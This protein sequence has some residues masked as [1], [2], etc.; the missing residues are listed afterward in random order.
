MKA[1]I[2]VI[3]PV[4][5]AARYL[6]RC[7]DSLVGQTYRELEII[8]VNDGSTDESVSILTEYA[9]CDSRV[10]VIHQENAGVSAARNAGLDAATGEYV[11]FVDADDWVESS[12][13]ECVVEHFKEP[14]DV[15][16]FGSE[17][18]GSAPD[19]E[20]Q[21]MQRYLNDDDESCKLLK[22]NVEGGGMNGCVWNKMF[23]R[24]ALDAHGVRFYEGIAYG[25]D[26]AFCYCVAGCARRVF[27]ISDR[28]Y[29]YEMHAE[30]ATGSLAGRSCRVFDH[31]RIVPLVWDFLQR[32][33]L[34]KRR[35]LRMID[36][37][38][39][40]A[41]G[42]VDS[43]IGEELR[44]DADSLAYEVMCRV[45]LSASYESSVVRRLLA[46]RQGEILGRFR[47]FVDNRMCFG[48]Q[49]RA[50]LSVTYEEHARIYRLLGV[51]VWKASV[52]DY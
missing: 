50:L 49:G 40:C 39:H 43:R 26:V 47:W 31:I 29:H 12:G 24:S 37:L 8:C 38:F 27:F 15:V 20:K 45:G 34:A 4:Y 1:L 11:T 7:L 46:P 10:K 42:Y 19:E 32:C 3:I 17:V 21:G 28:I 44:D 22:I 13:Y 6:P 14:V 5:N 23:R 16:C 25:E 48:V 9:G 52:A 41:Y 18:E 36:G 33:C 2:T 35:K 51:T 30:S